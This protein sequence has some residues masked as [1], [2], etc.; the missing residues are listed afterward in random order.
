MVQKYSV[1]LFHL[2]NTDIGYPYPGDLKA[3]ILV[4]QS[5]QAM[6]LAEPALRIIA[7]WGKCGPW[8]TAVV[9]AWQQSAQALQ[10]RRRVCAAAHQEVREERATVAHTHIIC[11][12]GWWVWQWG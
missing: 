4:E 7:F 2:Y 3:A 10:P 9:N 1:F 5:H 11:L 6:L 12:C 8:M